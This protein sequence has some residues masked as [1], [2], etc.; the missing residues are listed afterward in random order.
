MLRR[1]PPHSGFDPPTAHPADQPIPDVG[2]PSERPLAATEAAT[3]VG[4]SDSESRE[5]AEAALACNAQRSVGLGW[6]L[7]IAGE[8][9]G[10]GP[11][12]CVG[13]QRS[14]HAV[15]PGLAHVLD[16]KGLFERGKR[17][18]AGGDPAV[19]PGWR[20]IAAS[21]IQEPCPHLQAI[22]YVVRVTDPAPTVAVEDDR[23]RGGP[24]RP[25]PASA[26][27]PGPLAPVLPGP[28]RAGGVAGV[29]DPAIMRWCSP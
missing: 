11:C 10:L 28:P 19:S 12:C 15:R 13:C 17:S 25:R 8:S 21:P 9:S 26:V 23:G 7:D 3:G 6:A 14:A 27:R 1:G 22:G 24:R 5:G 2:E 29:R 20:V 18:S 16:V 4:S